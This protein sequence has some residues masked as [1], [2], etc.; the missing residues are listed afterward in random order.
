MNIAAVADTIHRDG[1]V[2]SVEA[3]IDAYDLQRFSYDRDGPVLPPFAHADQPGMAVMADGAVIEANGCDLPWVTLIAF[4]PQKGASERCA[5]CDDFYPDGDL[6]LVDGGYPVCAD[7][8]DEA[9][10]FNG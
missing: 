3:F 1:M 4:R 9:E 5:W 10:R 8:L 7:C 6:H 2:W